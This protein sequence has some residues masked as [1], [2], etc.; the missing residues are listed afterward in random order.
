VY[1]DGGISGNRQQ[2]VLKKGNHR[3]IPVDINKLWYLDNWRLT[4][5]N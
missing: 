5:D 2:A 1:T 3:M 4:I